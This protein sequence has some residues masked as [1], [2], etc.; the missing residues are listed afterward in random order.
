MPHLPFSLSTL[1]FLVVNVFG[2]GVLAASMVLALAPQQSHAAPV[3]LR[4][5]PAGGT[6]TSEF[7]WRQDPFTKSQ[8]F[9][10]GLDIAAPSGSPVYAPEN[11][12]VLFAGNY[13]GYGNLVVLKHQ[14]RGLYTLYGH[15]TKLLVQQ[16]SLVKP[17]QPI[18]LVGSTGR[19]TGAHLHFEVHYNSQY[20]NPV[21]YLLFLQQEFLSQHG[22]YANPAANWVASQLPSTGAPTPLPPAM[23]GPVVN[24]ALW[25]SSGPFTANTPL[26]VA[27]LKNLPV[28]RLA[29]KGVSKQAGK[30][31]A[32]L[33][34]HSRLGKQ[35]HLNLNPH[36]HAE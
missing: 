17:G 25:A 27:S 2:L 8:K 33:Q 18:A 32:T 11:A 26:L 23:G 13:G 29:Y 6:I 34:G 36:T 9:H 14:R 10:S 7:G 31:P 21:D 1:R 35:G 20:M 22:G 16:N 15:N 19:S 5:A 24:T 30:K 3:N 4:F 12:N 28:V